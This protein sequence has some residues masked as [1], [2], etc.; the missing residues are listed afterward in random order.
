M[1]GELLSLDPTLP[2]L[3]CQSSF[4]REEFGVLAC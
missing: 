3:A 2:G 4:R 1:G